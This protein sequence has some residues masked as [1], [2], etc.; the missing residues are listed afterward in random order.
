MEVVIVHTDDDGRMANLATFI[1]ADS[2][3]EYLHNPLLSSHFDFSSMPQSNGDEKHLQDTFSL[4]FL[5]DPKNTT[6]FQYTGSQDTPPCIEGVE[7]FVMAQP[8][9]MN[10]GDMEEYPQSLVGNARVLQRDH[11]R[12]VYM[13]DKVTG[14]GISYDRPNGATYFVDS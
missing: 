11:G 10:N 12:K 4:S 6:F 3:R 9:W 13:G 14:Q 2:K 8:Q 1:K 5:I 7:W